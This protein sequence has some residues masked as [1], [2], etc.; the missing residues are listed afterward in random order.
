MDV[1]NGD[2]HRLCPAR[3]SDAP[4]M[5]RVS[6]LQ[7]ALLPLIFVCRYVFPSDPH[8]GVI[9]LTAEDRPFYFNEYSGE[10]SVDFPR[11]ERK[12][13][14]GILAYVAMTRMYRL[15]NPELLSPGTVRQLAPHVIPH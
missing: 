14:G 9:D 6:G 8:Q 13:R 3:P 1:F 4:S 10:L 15:A 7:R 2:E 11:A 12:F 5:E